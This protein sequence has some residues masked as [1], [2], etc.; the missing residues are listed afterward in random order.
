MKDIADIIFIHTQSEFRQTAICRGG[1]RRFMERIQTS[2]HRHL[3]NAPTLH[4]AEFKTQSVWGRTDRRF[5]L[6]LW[7]IF[8][9][10]QRYYIAVLSHV[11]FFFLPPLPVAKSKGFHRLFP[12]SRHINFR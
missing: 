5:K 11:F 8:Y 9:G 10:E 7:D 4:L 3:L 1:E 2:N 6:W 12:S